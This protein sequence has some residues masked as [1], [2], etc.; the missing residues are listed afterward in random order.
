MARQETPTHVPICVSLRPLWLLTLPPIPTAV[1]ATSEK[2]D[3]S[4]G[5]RNQERGESRPRNRSSG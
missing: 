4:T 5:V 2:G 1:T 3:Q